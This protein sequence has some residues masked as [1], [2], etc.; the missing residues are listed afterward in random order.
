MNDKFVELLNEYLDSEC[1]DYSMK[2]S[3]EWNSDTECCDVT[4]TNDYNKRNTVICFR[5]NK[6]KNSLE[7]LLNEDFDGWYETAEHNHTVKYFW[8][9]VA[10]EIFPVSV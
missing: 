4:I 2:Y 7:I 3:Y 10:P 6:E 8:M 9:L 5:Y 1:S